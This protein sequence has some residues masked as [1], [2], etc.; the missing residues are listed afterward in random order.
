MYIERIRTYINGFSEDQ[1]NAFNE[2]LSEKTITIYKKENYPPSEAERTLN[3]FLG[4]SNIS[5]QSFE[6]ILLTIDEVTTVNGA[7]EVLN[8]N[9]AR[10]SK[11][12]R[13]IISLSAK[14]FVPHS[15]VREHLNDKVVL[16]EI[17]TLF[18]Y[19][20]MYCADPDREKFSD[21]L[22]VFNSFLEIKIDKND[23]ERDGS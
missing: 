4:G 16:K 8:G 2:K 1:K 13:D 18:Q 19:A 22:H 10:K 11:N 23:I 6:A 17:K 7:V 20:I 3:R 12:W 21:R 5:S 9:V 14:D 15:K